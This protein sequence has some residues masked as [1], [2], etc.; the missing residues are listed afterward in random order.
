VTHYDRSAFRYA[1]RGV[2]AAVSGYPGHDFLEWEGRA[3][4]RD[5]DPTNGLFVREL[6][7]PV[8]EE[9][10]S[11]GYIIARG[12]ANYDVFL[13]RGALIEPAETLAKNI[14]EAFAGGQSIAASGFSIVV[15]RSERGE[16]R[17]SPS[18]EWSFIPTSFSWYVYTAK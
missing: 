17:P 15:N 8:S 11:S 4:T 18:P 10:S 12:R 16:L 9:N 13:A 14:A 2:L 1:A 6:L 7:L 3:W 5:G